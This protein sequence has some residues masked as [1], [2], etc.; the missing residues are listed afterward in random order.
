MLP[1]LLVNL[2]GGPALHHEPIY[3]IRDH[4]FQ[5]LQY[6][7]YLFR[8]RAQFCEDWLSVIEQKRAHH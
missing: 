6:R 4:Q 1:T 5:P 7:E 2:F 8:H 3:R